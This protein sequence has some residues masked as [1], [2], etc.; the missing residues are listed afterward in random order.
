MKKATCSCG[1]LEVTVSAEPVRVSVCHCHECQKRTGS[2]FG[3]QARFAEGDVS[4]SGKTTQWTRTAESG[5]RIT[6]QF[7][8]VCGST[9]LYTLEAQPGVVAVALGAFAGQ[10]LP[11]PAYTVYE[12]RQHPWVEVKGE[13][14]RYD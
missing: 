9:V 13:I 12:A 8:P 2:A 5:N 6:F 4:V 14:E 7:C 3:A 11:A 1:Q 10:T